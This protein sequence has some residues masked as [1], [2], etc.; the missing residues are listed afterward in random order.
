MASK[1]HRSGGRRLLDSVGADISMG[2]PEELN[3][4]VQVIYEQRSSSPG[5][6]NTEDWLIKHAEKRH[7]LDRDQFINESHI[8]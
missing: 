7:Y 4:D 3:T 2:P 1:L 5:K 6:G 8:L